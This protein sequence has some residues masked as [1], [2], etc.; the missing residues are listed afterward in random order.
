M[1][2]LASKSSNL[3]C[4]LFVAST[5]ALVLS[6]ATSLWVAVTQSSLLR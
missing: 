4:D 2:E 5:K 1:K 3:S 6:K